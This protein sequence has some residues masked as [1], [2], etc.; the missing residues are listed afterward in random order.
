M[1]KVAVL[2]QLGDCRGDQLGDGIAVDGGADGDRKVDTTIRSPPIER[3]GVQPAELEVVEVADE[4]DR[5]LSIEAIA[6]DAVEPR[7][8]DATREAVE[9]VSIVI[10][11]VQPLL[12]GLQQ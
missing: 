12:T 10:E 3:S 1:L 7:P 2:R 4:V 11:G 8:V 6:I 5:E 9:F